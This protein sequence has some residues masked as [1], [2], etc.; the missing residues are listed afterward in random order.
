MILEKIAGFLPDTANSVEHGSVVRLKELIDRVAESCGTKVNFFQVSRGVVVVGLED[1]KQLERV[2][3]EFEGMEGVILAQ[4]TL[5]AFQREQNRA[6][7]EKI[8][9]MRARKKEKKG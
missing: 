5:A 6:A 9:K 7:Q 2:T 1:E 3:A 4:I 8:N